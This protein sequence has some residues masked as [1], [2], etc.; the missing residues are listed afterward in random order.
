MILVQALIIFG[1]QKLP[2]IGR[3]VGQT[4]SEFKKSARDLTN[5]TVKEIEKAQETKEE[6]TKK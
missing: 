4:L 2:Q 6:T 1:P 5:E 3:A